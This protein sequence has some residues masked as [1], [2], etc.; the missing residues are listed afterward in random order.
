MNYVLYP[1]YRVHVTVGRVLLSAAPFGLRILYSYSLLPACIS[2]VSIYTLV[3]RWSL[4]GQT[5]TLLDATCA[6]TRV[7]L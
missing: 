4:D 6:V 5:W 2:S 3:G 1:D 7:K